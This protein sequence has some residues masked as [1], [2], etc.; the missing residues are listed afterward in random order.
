MTVVVLYGVVE[1]LINAMFHFFQVST[2]GDFIPH[3]RQQ[4]YLR[5]RITIE[6]N[7]P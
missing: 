1:K 7:E 4:A 5:L 2:T 6:G 3:L